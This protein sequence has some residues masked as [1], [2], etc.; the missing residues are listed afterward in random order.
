[1]TT[2]NTISVSKEKMI[3]GFPTILAQDTSVICSYTSFGSELSPHNK[4][5]DESVFG[6]TH[7]VLNPAS[8]THLRDRNW[9]PSIT[10]RNWVTLWSLLPNTVIIPLFQLLFHLPNLL[11]LPASTGRARHSFP[12]SPLN[13]PTSTINSHFCLLCPIHTFQWQP[14]STYDNSTPPDHPAS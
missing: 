7:P 1:M 3:N 9:Q 8:P 5:T 2:F 14:H 6:N 11:P 10:T 4:P 13:S 12:G